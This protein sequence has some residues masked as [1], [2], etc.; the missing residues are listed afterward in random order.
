MKAQGQLTIRLLGPIDVRA[1]DGRD[2]TPPGKK[3]RTL[4]ACLALSS[5]K[6]WAREKLS[7]LLWG[8][9]G[10]EQARASLRQALA[11]LRKLLGDGNPLRADRETVGMD[12][13][14]VTIDVVE[15]Q[16]LA[17]AGALE[18]AA[19]L[20]RGDLLD[21]QSLSDPEFAGLIAIERTRLR[22]LA[23][24]VLTKLTECQDGE[25]AVAAAQRMIE[26]DPLR[27]ESHRVLMRLYTAA[28]QRD[29]ALRQ[30]QVCREALRRELDVDPE[31]ETDL[32]LKEIQRT[33]NGTDKHLPRSIGGAAIASAGM[34]A[35]DRARGRKRVLKPWHLAL[36]GL[37]VLL[38]GAATLQFYLRSSTDDGFPSLAVMPFGNLGAD[39]AL[40]VLADGITDQAITMASRFPDF[41]VVSRKVSGEFEDPAEAA[42]EIGANYVLLGS[43]QRKGSG[44]R[45]NAQLVDAD[46]GRH[47][48]ADGY[49][50][51]DPAALQDQSVRKIIVS[52]TGEKGA[53]KQAEYE[54]LKGKPAARLTEYDYYLK[55]HELFARWASIEE[56]DRAGAIWRE[57]LEKFPD[58]SLLKVQLGW[59]HFMRPWQYEAGKPAFERRMAGEY[60]RAALASENAPPVVQWLGH[61]LMAYIHWHEGNFVHAIR[62]AEIAVALNPH[63]ANMRSFLARVQIAAGNP[64]RAIEWVQS[65]LALAPDLYR[66]TRILA[67][68]YYLT[69]EY[70]KSIAQAERHIKLS[71]E[72]PAEVYLYIA[73]DNVRLGRMD[74]ARLALDTLR[75]Q[76]PNWSLATERAWWLDWPYKD[77]AVLE[78]WLK[79][80]ASA[81]FPEFGFLASASGYERLTTADLKALTFGHKVHARDLDTG[82]SYVDTIAR[83]GS[84]QTAGDYGMDSATISYLEDGLICYRWRDWGSDCGSIFRKRSVSERTEYEYLYLTSCCRYQVTIE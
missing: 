24:D 26:I 80:L 58:S 34:S 79:D 12:K 56:H 66:N 68:A 57:G 29:R 6:A 69:G 27:E 23:I 59:Y 8:D 5:G 63:D 39:P 37:A 50:G 2:V 72:F 13:T 52:L 46:T 45:V 35:P 9:R 21:G 31:P 32:L 40:K 76:K 28:G 55:G 11:D 17:S 49:E 51:T 47:I 48:W 75:E 18:E 36:V 25:R 83:D 78:R 64:E 16:R 61:W 10:E 65:T 42:R 33:A 38:I 60:A 77:H 30:Y 41:H 15:F 81:G 20:Y 71:R 82:K 67:W 53:I 44:L 62:D 73:A 1:A 19:A 70:E 3:L 22:D 7:G 54:R 4:L 43:V 84:A 74:A 14:A